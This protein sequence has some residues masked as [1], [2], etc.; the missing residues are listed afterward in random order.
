MYQAWCLF[1]LFGISVIAYG[2]NNCVPRLE[3]KILVQETTVRL[4]NNVSAIVEELIG[5][6]EFIILGSDQFQ[7]NVMD[8]LK[9]LHEKSPK[10]FKFVKERISII[11]EHY[12]SGIHVEGD[13]PVF[14]FNINSCP[15]DNIH[16][17]AS[18]LF[19]ESWH[20]ELYRKG[21][22]YT[23]ENAEHLCNLHQ[24]D[25]LVKLDSNQ[26]NIDHLVSIIKKGDHSDLDGDGDYDWDDYRLREQRGW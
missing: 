17:C 18:V 8:A 19:H 6:D 21:K 11:K 2:Q 14:D 23:G 16:W 24:K 1:T 13:H 10:M 12:V 15:T 7:K 22:P 4:S 3:R 25:A 9:L 20:V 26:T 5:G